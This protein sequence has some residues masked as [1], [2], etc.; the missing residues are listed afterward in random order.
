MRGLY[1][2]RQEE[3]K[4]FC[5]KKHQHTETEIAK[6]RAANLKKKEDLTKEVG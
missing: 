6:K 3:L 1:K 5:I 4:Q 2:H